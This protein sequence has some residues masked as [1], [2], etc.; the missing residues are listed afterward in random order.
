MFRNDDTV[1]R[2][3]RLHFCRRWPSADRI[4]TSRR[5]AKSET[6]VCSGA[7]FLVFFFLLG[8][9]VVGYTAFSRIYAAERRRNANVSVNRCLTDFYFFLT[10]GEGLNVSIFFA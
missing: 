8:V 6:I 9:A 3:G 4:S 1:L 5:S 7:V 10:S 2:Q